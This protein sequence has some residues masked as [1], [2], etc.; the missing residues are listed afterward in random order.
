MTWPAE[1]GIDQ[2]I[3]RVG[4]QTA[5]ASRLGVTQQ[6]VSLWARR[7]WVPVQRAA[8]IEHHTGVLRQSLIKPALRELLDIRSA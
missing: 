7:G 1:T 3:A 8:E 6:V 2:A 5:L 4:T